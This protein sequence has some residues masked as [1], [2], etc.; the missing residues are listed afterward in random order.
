MF[1]FFL[2]FIALKKFFSNS[3]DYKFFNQIYIE[4]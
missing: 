3:K 4:K 2:D 1:F